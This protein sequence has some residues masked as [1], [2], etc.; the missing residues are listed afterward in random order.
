M[1]GAGFTRWNAVEVSV[2]DIS[3]CYF[4]CSIGGEDSVP[5]GIGGSGRCGWIKKE[6]LCET[7]VV[8]WTQ[9]RSSSQSATDLRGDVSISIMAN[10]GLGKYK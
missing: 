5:A 4:W 10:T 3:R 8:A 6:V 7:I 1:D 2:V 9:A